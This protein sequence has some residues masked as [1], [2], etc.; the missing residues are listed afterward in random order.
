MKT[1]GDNEWENKCIMKEME[2]K[3]YATKKERS[4]P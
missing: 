3:D 4:F 2:E 1:E